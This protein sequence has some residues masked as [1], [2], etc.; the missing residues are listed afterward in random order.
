MPCVYYRIG[1]RGSIFSRAIVPGQVKQIPTPPAAL[2]VEEE[3]STF[4]FFLGNKKDMALSFVSCPTSR[5]LWAIPLFADPRGYL[6]S[7]IPSE[8]RD[9]NTIVCC[10][11]F[12]TCRR[13]RSVFHVCHHIFSRRGISLPEASRI[14]LSSS[15]TAQYSRNRNSEYVA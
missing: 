7:S 14:P 3:S 6:L 1:M 12:I 8:S 15:L 11:L 2:K 5:F 13:G 4:F 9:R 10:V